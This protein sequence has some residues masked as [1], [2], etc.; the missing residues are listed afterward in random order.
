MS[1]ESADRSRAAI[2]RELQSVNNFITE[3]QA[4]EIYNVLDAMQVLL[5]IPEGQRIVVDKTRRD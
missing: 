3:A 4:S 5:A 1:K 2:I